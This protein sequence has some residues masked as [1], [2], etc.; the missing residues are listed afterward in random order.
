MTGLGEEK[1]WLVIFDCDG[2]LVDSEG[3][4]IANLQALLADEGLTLEF[5]AIRD[6]FL[7]RSLVFTVESIA[8]EFGKVLPP[9]FE[10]R[11]RAE[12][13]RRFEKE[14][15]ALPGIG[16]TLEVL[17]KDGATICVASSSQPER[18]RKSLGMTGLL[19]AFSGNIFSA[20]MV[21]KG[22]P[23]PDLFLYAAE[24][25]GVSPDRC[26][27]IEDSPTGIR[28]AKAA[29]MPVFAFTGGSHANNAVYKDMI[30]SLNPD[31]EFDVMSDLLQLVRRLGRA[32]DSMYA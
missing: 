29:K 26:L 16:E 14:L 24:K 17:K 1:G 4:A 31:A 22:K 7:G 8:R 21:E 6:R 19:E 23:A 5:D 10:E 32:K 12:L 3:I 25:L 20:T 28:A 30:H 27:V 15:Q 11:L 13:Y 9:D 18:I 2:V